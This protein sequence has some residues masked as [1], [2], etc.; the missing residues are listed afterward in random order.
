RLGN[1]PNRDL[2]S[3]LRNVHHLRTLDSCVDGHACTGN[4]ELSLTRKNR[5]YG[6]RDAA[7][8]R[9]AGLQT[10]LLDKALV[11][12]RKDGKIET[13]VD[14]LGY[15]YSLRGHSEPREPGHAKASSSRHACNERA[16]AQVN[17][18]HGNLPVV[19]RQVAV[20]GL[21]FRQLFFALHLG[22]G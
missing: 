8:G 21:I 7:C 16:A 12:G 4:G 17:T 1:D 18:C 11:H 6:L 3:N 19:V 15:S 2:A 13:E 5:W 14:G 10:V 22:R 9:Q 20:P